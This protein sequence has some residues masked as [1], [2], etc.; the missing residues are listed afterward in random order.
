MSQH[1]EQEKIQNSILSLRTELAKT[2]KRIEIIEQEKEVAKLQ[3][4]FYQNLVKELYSL[5]IN[6]PSP[7]SKKY[8]LPSKFSIACEAKKFRNSNFPNECEINFEPLQES[9]KDIARA[10]Y[11]EKIGYYV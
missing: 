9:Y 3:T 10:E 4:R 11:I 1:S 5:S 7:V 6:Q 2:N 8:L